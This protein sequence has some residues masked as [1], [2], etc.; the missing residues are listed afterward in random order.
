MNPPEPGP[1][2]EASRLD[3]IPTRA[4]LLDQAHHGP[5]EAAGPA[6]NALVLRYRRAVRGYLGALLQDD[7]LADEVAHDVLVRILE[8]RFAGA[9]LRRGRFRDYLKR[10]VRNAAVSALRAAGRV[11]GTADA[12]QF[13]DDLP[14]AAAPEQR[15]LDECRLSLLEG[16]TVR[17]AEYQR[18]HAGNV[19]AT[20]LRLLAE[21]PEDDSARLAERLREATGQ[22]YRADAVRQQVGRARRKF[23][24]FLLDEVRRSLDEP[25][26]DAVEAELTEL[27]LMDYVRDFLPPDWRS[28]EGGRQ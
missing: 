28:A 14:A 24:Q 22:P 2:G 6:R 20:L 8:G 13:A 21:H 27:G 11:R 23:A 26:P 16:A 3:A 12:E 25:T 10:A 7:H 15:W 17:L 4:S 5:P 1:A 18:G 9:D 19:Y